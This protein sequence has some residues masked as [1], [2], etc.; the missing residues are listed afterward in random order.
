MGRQ[1]QRL[2]P[3]SPPLRSNQPDLLAGSSS[4]LGVRD[5]C[6]VLGAARTFVWSEPW[7]P[8]GCGPVAQLGPNLAVL[9]AE[10]PTGPLIRSFCS[11]GRG[12]G[13]ACWLGW[14]LSLSSLR[15]HTRTAACTC[16]TTFEGPAAQS[17][18]P[19]LT[20]LLN[21]QLRNYVR[22]KTT[23]PRE[24]HPAPDP[25]HNP[26]PTTTGPCSDHTTAAS[27][28]IALR[29][30]KQPLCWACT[31]RFSSSAGPAARLPGCAVTAMAGGRRARPA[32]PDNRPVCPEAGP[33]MLLLQRWRQ[34]RQW[35]RAPP[36]VC[37]S[38]PPPARSHNL[39]K[40]PA[41][42]TS[43]RSDLL[44]LRVMPSAIS[45][46][47]R[48]VISCAICLRT[49][50]NSCGCTCTAS[51]LFSCKHQGAAMLS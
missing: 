51:G 50:W 2:L 4:W 1:Q 12:D 9:S 3:R 25:T 20:Q 16:H 27:S 8:P 48:T 45:R 13:L 38:P 49:C 7:Q 26:Q 10:L 41:T 39:P 18:P 40:P 29:P 14:T 21:T 34:R 22:V 44:C 36:A 32:E 30:L 6:C 31:A 42:L 43:F 17:W 47:R 11:T 35:S 33:D 46:S 19:A 5:S 15:G 28:C 23:T 24:P 37:P